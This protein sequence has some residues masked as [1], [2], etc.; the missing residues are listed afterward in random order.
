MRTKTLLLTAALSA[1]GLAS[2]TAQVYSVNAVGYV[3]VSVPAHKL[4]ILG[5]PLNGTNN[6][7]N[8]T[9]PLAPGV[10]GPYVFRWDPA[11][12]GYRG[13]VQWVDAFG[14]YDPDAPDPSISPTINPGEAFWFQNTTPNAVAITYVGEVPQGNLSIDIPGRPKLALRSS[15]VPQAAPL[16][17]TDPTLSNKAGSL[18]FPAA[19]GDYVFI[20]DVPTQTYL[21]PFQYVATYGWYSGN[22]PEPGPQGPVI[23]VA[24]GFWIQ[25]AAAGQNWTRTFS[26]N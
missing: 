14:W 24:G 12:S 25:K 15:Q 19:D 7:M 22:V 3:N 4:A 8:T 11:T 6:Q 26:V 13:P 1:A 9:M 10:D 2:A 20:W 16:G 18:E 17:D 23:P 21:Q 5:V